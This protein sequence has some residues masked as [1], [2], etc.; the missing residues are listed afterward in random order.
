MKRSGK[1]FI[2][3]MVWL[4][5]IFMIPGG[6]IM[7]HRASTDIENLVVPR[8]VVVSAGMMFFNAGIVVGLLDSGFNA[9][10]EKIWFAFFHILVLLSVPALLLADFN[11]VAFE[12][13]EREFGM[14]ISIPG[15][16]ALLTDTGLIVVMNE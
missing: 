11:W 14:G 10:R 12:P 2:K 4:G 5:L 8:W 13:G 3:G 9:L 16:G 1:D 15:S 7:R 6:V